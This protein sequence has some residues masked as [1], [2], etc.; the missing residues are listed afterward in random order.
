MLTELTFHAP[1][2]PKLSGTPEEQVKQLTKHVSDLKRSL[3]EWFTELNKPGALR[4]TQANVS[5]PSGAIGSGTLPLTFDDDQDTGMYATNGTVSIVVDGADILVVVNGST[6]YVQ[7]S[8]LYPTNSTEALPGVALQTDSNTGIHW[9]G[10]DSIS[11]VTGGTKRTTVDGSA[12]LTHTGLVDLSGAAAG[13]IKFPA[14]QNASSNAN[15]LDDYEEGTWTPT[16]TAQTGSFTTVSGTGRYQKIGN[17]V[18]FFVSVTI[19]DAG[20]ATGGAIFTLPFTASGNWAAS[21]VE[22]AAVFTALTCAVF[23]ANGVILSYDG[24]SPIAAGRVLYISGHYAT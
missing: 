9:N 15:T 4:I 19:T 13:Q 17:T 18:H 1:E 10:G 3:Q 21:G 22:V 12:V 24:T 14:S 16:V 2:D 8:R 20:T 7:V 11:I 23:G 5:I 6:D